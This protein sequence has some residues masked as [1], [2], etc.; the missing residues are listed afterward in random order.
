[1]TGGFFGCI[2]GNLLIRLTRMGPVAHMRPP[3]PRTW[4][5][6]FLSQK[7]LKAAKTYLTEAIRHSLAIGHGHGPT[8]PF[9]FL[10]D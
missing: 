5:K 9:Y 4:P 2:L 7:R 6:A 8:N 3:L 10:R 1:M